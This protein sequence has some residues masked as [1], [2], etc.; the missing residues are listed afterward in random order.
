[1]KIIFSGSPQY[2]AELFDVDWEGKPLRGEAQKRFCVLVDLECASADRSI[3]VAISLKSR[4]PLERMPS[5]ENSAQ[6]YAAAATA[7]RVA[8]EMLPRRQEWK[9][10][11]ATE[12]GIPDEISV[13]GDCKRIETE[14]ELSAALENQLSRV[15]AQHRE[16]HEAFESAKKF[17][18]THLHS[19]PHYAH[20]MA[21]A[22]FFLASCMRA[23][24]SFFMG[25][26][27]REKS[28]ALLSAIGDL[29][30][31]KNTSHHGYSSS[32]D[33]VSSILYSIHP[34]KVWA[35]YPPSLQSWR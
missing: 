23:D 9:F 16:V 22:A 14:V 26:W 5:L 35:D 15:S 19:A 28:S 8:M 21:E 32:A 10:Y 7:L 31:R 3:D 30:R 1:M 25:A 27:N 11:N 33:R 20:E 6:T 17:L 13:E 12:V 2:A 4:I 29:T 18:S 34:P 24:G